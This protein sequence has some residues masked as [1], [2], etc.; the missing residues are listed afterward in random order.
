M[1][2]DMV[3][4]M[5]VIFYQ[6]TVLMAHEDFINFSGFK[7]GCMSDKMDGREDEEEIENVDS[8]HESVD[9]GD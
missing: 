6:L 5:S 1:G 8:E 9:N 4:E 2:T 3:P 7:S